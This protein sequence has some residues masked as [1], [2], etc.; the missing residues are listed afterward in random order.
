MNTANAASAGADR[1][2]SRRTSAPGRKHRGQAAVEEPHVGARDVARPSRASRVVPS[3]DGT[4]AGYCG[5]V[6]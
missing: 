2:H 1:G 6:P 5:C 4:V 3:L